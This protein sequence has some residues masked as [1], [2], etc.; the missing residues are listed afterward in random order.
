MTEIKNF[1]ARIENHFGI[2]LTKMSNEEELTKALGT[3]S[4]DIYVRLDE[5][6]VCECF[7][8]DNEDGSIQ[9]CYT[10]DEE[11]CFDEIWMEGENRNSILE[12][13]KAAL[14]TA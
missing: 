10:I 1:F 11:G 13:L 5:D 3:R 2:D 4:D 6:G 8:L 9:L 7:C 12:Q 14:A